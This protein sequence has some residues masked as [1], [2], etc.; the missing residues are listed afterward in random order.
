MALL[1]VA[2][3]HAA[4]NGDRALTGTDVVLVDELFGVGADVPAAQEARLVGE[5]RLKVAL[6]HHVVLER[7]V[8]H[9]AVLVTVLGDVA[10]AHHAALADGRMGDVLTAEL[11]GAG[12]ERL[13]AGQTVDE[14][15]LAVAVDAGKADDLAAAD[16]ERNVLDGIVLVELGGHGHAL[17]LED[18]LARLGGLFVHMEADIAADHHRRQLLHRGVGRFDRVVYDTIFFRQ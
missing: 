16:L 9:K 17:D 8:E 4:G 12:N 15:R 5:L 7:I 14:L 6:E 1:L 13:Q 10:H 2:A 11:D 3:G 18:D